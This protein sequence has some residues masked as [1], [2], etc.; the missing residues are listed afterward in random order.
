MRS[1]WTFEFGELFGV[2]IRL[3]ISLLVTLAWFA[4]GNPFSDASVEDLWLASALLIALF[5]HES[6]HR[7]AALGFGIK[8]HAL[9]VFPFGAISSLSRAPS[10]R[11]QIVTAL[12]GPVSNGIVV[13]VLYLTALTSNPLMDLHAL[14]SGAFTTL[15][16]L[17]KVATVNLAIA[18]LNL[19]PAVPL[20]GGRILQGFLTLAKVAT[21]SATLS[22]VNQLCCLIMA[23]VAFV[24]SEPVLFFAAF[25]VFFGALQ[26]HLRTEGRAAASAFLVKDAMIPASR[27]ESLTHGSTVSMA[28][29]VALTSLQPFFPIM[30]H[31]KLVGFVLRDAILE[32]N[33]LSPDAYLNTISV[34]QLE[35]I[36]VEKPLTEALKLFELSGAPMLIAKQ[37]EQFAGVLIPERVAEF[38]ILKSLPKQPADGDDI[39]W[40]IS[41]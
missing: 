30:L 3:H 38:V 9:T 25:V 29:K 8:T 13:T 17:Q 31:E 20:D 5:F 21:P 24:T 26:E 32:H 15:S 2:S 39:P 28:V 4:V 16:P 22:R 33:A 27:L 19:I 34:P 18:L 37:G 11:A 6:A 7:A 23:V 10:P 35:D 14:T 41:P 12:A 36:G 40:S 1:L